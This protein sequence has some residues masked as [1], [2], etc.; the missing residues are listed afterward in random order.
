M[1]DNYQ[2]S[3]T[4]ETGPGTSPVLIAIAWAAVMIPLAWGF[5]STLA[6]ASLLFR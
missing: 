4:T 6:K 2:K 3:D 1:S 5:L